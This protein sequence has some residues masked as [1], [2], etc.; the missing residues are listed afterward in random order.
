M[1][2]Y[3]CVCMYVCMVVCM[4]VCM[5]V[6]MYVCMY[7]WLYVCMYVCIVVCMH[8]CIVVCMH[9]C[10]SNIS[11]FAFARTKM[12]YTS[13]TVCTSLKGWIEVGI[14]AERT[15]EAIA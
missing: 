9:V 1:F 8:V 12:I 3:I 2:G 7:V 4:Y 14:P 10:I 5:V 11:M 6:C 15:S 13:G